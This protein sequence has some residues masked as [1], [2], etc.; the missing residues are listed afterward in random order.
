MLSYD[1]LRRESEHVRIALLGPPGSGKGTQ[2]A[3]L[4]D[5]LGV[6]L[7]S[8]GDLL[9]ARATKRPSRHL[10]SAIERGDLVPDDLV[11]RVVR[12]ALTDVGPKGYVLDGLPRTL[13]QA[14]SADA[15]PV[16]VVVH[17]AVPDDIARQRLAGRAGSGRADDANR[18]VID[19]R[20]R[21]Y[22]AETEPLLD[23]YRTRGLLRTVDATHPPAAVAE[24]IRAALTDPP[25]PT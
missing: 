24:A 16:D 7:I 25:E 12:E 11:L 10:S 20:L 13:A 17:L 21:T 4:A 5:D 3:R 18:A 19:H 6:P 9:R 2:G 22:H 1:A 14:Q 8:S 15:P 23:H